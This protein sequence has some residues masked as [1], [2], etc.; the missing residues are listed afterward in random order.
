[1]NETNLAKIA[2][3]AAADKAL[4]ESLDPVNMG[5]EGGRVT[6]TELATWYILEGVKRLGPAEITRI[7]EEYF[8]Q[9]TYLG[10]L[11]KRLKKAR[12]HG[13][14]DEEAEELLKRFVPGSRKHLKTAVTK[15]A[16]INDET[17]S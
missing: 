10:A 11:M 17:A 3:T 7:R 15:P 6:K 4:S 1:M 13:V 12:A 14:N 16:A 5:F 8:D 9:L 2:I